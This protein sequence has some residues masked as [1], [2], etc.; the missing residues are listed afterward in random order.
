MNEPDTLATLERCFRLLAGARRGSLPNT[1]ANAGILLSR[2]LKRPVFER[3]KHRVTCMDHNLFDVIWPAL[4]KYNKR[5]GTDSET[6]SISGSRPQSSYE[7]QFTGH[8]VAPDYESYIVFTELF[9]PLIRDIHCLTATGQLPDHPQV[10]FFRISEEN[11]EENLE[12]SASLLENYDLDSS[13][14]FILSGEIECTRNLRNYPLPL[15][16]TVNQLENS[17][18]EITSVLMRQELAIILSEGTSKDESGTYYTLIEVL[19]RPSDV[20]VRLAA[21]GLLSPIT[22]TEE[23]DERRLHGKHWPYGRG[24]FIAAAGNLA[25]WVNVLDHIRVIC[26]TSEDKPG[27]IGKAYVRV[28]KLMNVLDQ[29]LIFKR[30]PKL[31]FLS[32]RPSS[33][34]NTLRFHLRV[35]FPMLSKDLGNLK[36]LCI[37]RGLE[38][39]ETMRRNIVRIGNQQS[40]SI[41]EMQTLQDFCKAVLNVLS[42]EKEMTLN[43]SM[44]ITNVIANI[45]RK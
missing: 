15:T 41:T 4:E 23:I 10:S 6:N 32:A 19:E 24:V 39:R 22:E 35:K 42:L 5:N 26:S 12:K 33:I 34:G 8:V 14:K 29:K 44:K 9:D 7:D 20:R 28:A 3:L 38:F 11:S 21:A 36:N 16:L 27:K 17:E 25:I 31:G 40:L 30:D 43:N 45:F 18:R 1:P 13:R 37:V 2:C